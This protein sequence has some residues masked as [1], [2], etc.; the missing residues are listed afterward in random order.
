VD[1]LF[2]A[3]DRFKGKICEIHGRA[4][5]LRCSERMGY[6]AD[7]ERRMGPLWDEWNR[8]YESSTERCG[9]YVLVDENT[10]GDAEFLQR[11]RESNRTSSSPLICP[12]CQRPLR[13]N[14]LLFHDTDANILK[15]ISTQRDR[16]Q[17]WE[18]KMEDDVVLNGKNLVILELG[19]GKNV[20]AVREEGEEVLRDIIER[21]EKVMSCQNGRRNEQKKSGNVTMV[22]INPKDAE[23]E[24]NVDGE[25]NL[26]PHTI[27]IFEPAE[28]ALCM[29]DNLIGMLTSKRTDVF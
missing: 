4:L 11:T 28:R 9:E 18:A 3:S 10:S 8:D 27:S 6:T 22:R 29:V 15:C 1:G 7:G 12:H 16:Y 24:L 14:I 13:P 20:P 25:P 23:A 19:C 17:N 21:T 2:D 26:S 5:E